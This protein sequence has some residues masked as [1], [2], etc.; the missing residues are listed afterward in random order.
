MKIL[1]K[2][3]SRADLIAQSENFNNNSWHTD[4]VRM[5]KYYDGF[6]MME[7]LGGVKG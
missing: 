4:P 7:Q 2:P 1:D 5:Q 3:T 6:V